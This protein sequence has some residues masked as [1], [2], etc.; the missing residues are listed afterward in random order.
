M[1]AGPSRMG[2]WDSHTPPPHAGV[3]LLSS[4]RVFTGPWE[5]R[6]PRKLHSLYHPPLLGAQ[7]SICSLGELGL[8]QGP[9]WTPQGSMGPYDAGLASMQ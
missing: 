6:T 3:L 8:S 2:T 4:P 9:E 5:K 7:P 1:G